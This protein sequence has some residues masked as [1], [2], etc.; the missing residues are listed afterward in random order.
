MSLMVAATAYYHTVA[1]VMLVRAVEFDALV[2]ST[3]ICP[4]IIQA[5]ARQQYTP[6]PEQRD[7]ISQAL[8][9]PRERF[10]WGHAITAEEFSQI[11]L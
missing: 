6:S 5:I 2:Q 11:R 9:F 8:H 4:R 10:I 3:G 1:E 7:R